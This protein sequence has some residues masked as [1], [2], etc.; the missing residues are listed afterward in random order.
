MAEAD[1]LAAVILATTQAVVAQNAALFL[2]QIVSE[3][4]G[5]VTI[6]RY[7]AATADAGGHPKLIANRPG[8]PARPG[9]VAL[10]GAVDPTRP[11]MLGEVILSGGVASTASPIVFTGRQNV[12]PGHG[13][14]I[15]YRLPSAASRLELFLYGFLPAPYRQKSAALSGTETGDPHIHA[16]QGSGGNLSYS[17]GATAATGTISGT[18]TA[19]SETWPTGVHLY[20]DGID[21][22]TALSGPWTGTSDWAAGPLNIL[23]WG[24]ASGAHTLTLTTTGSGLLEWVLYAYP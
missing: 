17:S 6:K 18:V 9:G 7:D 19:E 13:A 11:V 15:H 2:A 24:G 1:D 4:D 3:A 10:M 20:V 16:T 8:V 5:L 14:T 12:D 21:R 23:A 22:T